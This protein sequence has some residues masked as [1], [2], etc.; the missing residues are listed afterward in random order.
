MTNRTIRVALV[1]ILLGSVAAGIGAR[2]AEG[3]TPTSASASAPRRSLVVDTD[4]G[5]DDAMA[6]LYLLRHPAADVRAI[7]VSGTGLVHCDAGVAN[8]RGLVRAAGHRAVPVACG[9]TATSAGGTP[10]PDAWRRDADRRYGGVLPPGEPGVP[11]ATATGVWSDALR[12]PAT[13]VLLGPSTTAARVL[14]DD[15]SLA[16]RITRFVV[17]GGALRVAGNVVPPG[18]ERPG[19]V[20]WNLHADPVAADRVFRSGV[21]IA[22]VPLDATG[23]APLDASTAQAVSRAGDVPAVRPIADLLRTRPSMLDGSFFL[24]DPVAA[25]AAL[26]PDLL[27]WHDERVRVA[28]AGTDAGRVVLDPSGTPVRAARRVAQALVTGEWLSALA[29]RRVVPAT[30]PDVTVE[31]RSGGCR[32]TNRTFTPGPVVL[33]LVTP[34]GTPGAAAAFHLRD[35]RTLADLDAAL[36]LRSQGAPPWVDLAGL[37]FTDGSPATALADLRAQPYTVACFTATSSGAPPRRVGAVTIRP[38]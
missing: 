35:G 13:V 28:T 17:M 37:A 26:R 1:L 14:G 38:E 31:L 34:D 21:P 4:G 30:T 27:P 7:T 23:G 24:W 32:V 11:E 36:R 6:L 5:A 25:V 2:P 33:G 16:R 15:P 29:G 8:V 9:P 12:T 22:L 19:S 3:A 10:F 18:A 20:E